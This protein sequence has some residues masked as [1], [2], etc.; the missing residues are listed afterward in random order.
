LVEALR[1]LGYSEGRNVAF[2]WRWADNR[3]ENLPALAAELV[4][5]EVDILV[6][7][8]TTAA[9]AAKQATGTIPILFSIGTD[10]VKHGLVTSLARPGGNLTGFTS[11]SIGE[12][13]GKRLQFLKEAIP[14]LTK[15]GVLTDAQGSPPPRWDAA[16]GLGIE[17]H[18]LLLKTESDLE[19]TF[20]AATRSRVGGLILDDSQ[21]LVRNRARIGSLALRHRLPTIGAHADYAEAGLLMSYAPNQKVL[22]RRRAALVDRILRGDRD[23]RGCP[24]RRRAGDGRPPRRR[25]TPGPPGRTDGAL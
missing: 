5:L 24:G 3:L 13:A 25:L 16:H 23:G 4:R 22:I 6:T 11:T 1:E 15:V 10:P 8:G 21:I 9:K 2:H 17:V 14:E 20:A 18:Y 7:S 12:L 19:Q